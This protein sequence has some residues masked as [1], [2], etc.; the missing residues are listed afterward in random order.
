MNTILWNDDRATAS[1]Q[2]ADYDRRVRIIG[3]QTS[4]VLKTVRSY[5]G[6]VMA[7]VARNIAN[8][9]FQ[10]G[11]TEALGD[12][13]ARYRDPDFAIFGRIVPGTQ[14]CAV[15]RAS[16][17]SRLD[18]SILDAIFGISLL[19]SCGVI[20]TTLFTASGR[21]RWGSA[22]LFVL[23]GLLANAIVC[24][25]ISGN[26]ERYQSRVTWLVPLLAFAIIAWVAQRKNAGRAS[27]AE[28]PDTSKVGRQR[29]VASALSILP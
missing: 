28:T 10:Y 9:F 18:I 26:A 2:A 21:R 14:D 29:R 27:S 15:G 12:P 17:A 22:A 11:T 24:G 8:L 7:I 3:E 25:G 19:L 4:F 6:D 13:T 23:V 20:A 1:F 16:C 5:P